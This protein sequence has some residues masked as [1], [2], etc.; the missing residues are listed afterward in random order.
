MSKAIPATKE[1]GKIFYGWWIV[2]VASLLSFFGG[3]TF[4]YGFSAFV[5]PIVKDLGWSMTLT[6][7]AFSLYRLEAGLVA[8]LVGFLLDRIGPRKL[9]FSGGFFMGL[10]FIVLSRAETVFPFYLAFIFLSLGFSSFAGAAFGPP[11]IGKWFVRKRGKALGL[12][13]AAFGVGGLLVPVLAHFILHYGWRRTAFMLGL[14]SWLFVPA[15]SFI[16]KESPE[17]CGLL[18][19]G[20]R[21]RDV[22]NTSSSVTFIASVPEVNFSIRDSMRTLAFWSLTLCFFVFQ[23]NMGAMFV[24]LVPY[25]ISAGIEPQLA[26]FAV[27]FVAVLSILGRIG[28]G[29]LSDRYSKRKLLIFNFILQLIAVFALSQVRQ[30]ISITPCLAIF[31]LSYGGLIVLKP[32]VTG[33]YYGRKNFGTIFGMIQG[34]SVIGGIMGPIVMGL[35]YDTKGNYTSALI[36]IALL[37]LLPIILLL[38]LKRP[39]LGL[40]TV[41][42][43]VSAGIIVAH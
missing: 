43:A 39:T 26:A 27:T 28:F 30:I 11:F 9:V 12:Y 23:T 40:R 36:S 5:V 19:D 1:A 34:I 37:N 35:A 6:S 31:A 42:R 20:E 4:H 25:I 3:G 2:L 10:G 14:F 8:P 33:D 21:E 32:A 38:F 13:T 41:T 16:L 22:K 7:G 29:V 17:R 24:H 15:L 18:P